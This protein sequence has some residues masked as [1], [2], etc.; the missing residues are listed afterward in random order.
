MSA[1]K[2]PRTANKTPLGPVNIAAERLRRSPWLRQTVPWVSQTDS[3]EACP[4]GKTHGCD[5]SRGTGINSGALRSGFP[6]TM[7]AI[8]WVTAPLLLGTYATA[9]MVGTTA[10]SAGTDR[11]VM[12]HR[13]FRVGIL[14]LTALRMVC[15]QHT[16]IL[17]LLRDKPLALRRAAGG[18]SNG[19]RRQP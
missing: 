2:F 5:M 16:G 7:Q 9:W 4:R 15:R 8:H 1:E 17:S 12:V 13:S 18:L 19:G 6:K 11:P 14:L 3:G 10:S